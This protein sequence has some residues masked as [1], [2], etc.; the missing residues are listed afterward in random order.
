MNLRIKN[1]SEEHIFLHGN[2]SGQHN[3]GTKNDMNKMNYTKY[4]EETR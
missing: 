3:T 2:R 1:E 4:R